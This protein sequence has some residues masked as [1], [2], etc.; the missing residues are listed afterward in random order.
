MSAKPSKMSPKKRRSIQRS[1]AKKPD[2]TFT[3][4]DRISLSEFIEWGIVVLRI[5]SDNTFIEFNFTTRGFICAHTDEYGKSIIYHGYATISEDGPACITLD[6]M[7]TVDESKKLVPLNHPFQI[8]S[9]FRIC[10]ADLKKHI[11]KGN[12]VVRINQCGF[13]FIF[14]NAITPFSDTKVFRKFWT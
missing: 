11:L 9:G 13:G 14:D 3:Y 10:T 12:K 7:N 6:Y 4:S 1:L 8:K 5:D 2:I